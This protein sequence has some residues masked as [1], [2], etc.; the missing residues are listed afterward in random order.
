MKNKNYPLYLVEQVDDLQELINHAAEKYGDN[1]AFTFEQ[2]KKT[3]SISYRKFKADIEALGTALLNAGVKNTKVAVIGEN[4]YEWILTYFATVNSGN[5]IVPL[6][7][8]LPAVD[9]KNLIDTSG[10]EV[11]VHS[12]GYS[13]IAEYLT[14]NGVNIRHYIC[15]VK[16]PDM[17][18]NGCALIQQGDNSMKG[19]RVDNKALAVLLYTSGTTGMAKGVM[20]THIGLARGTAACLMNARIIGSNILVMPL[21]HVFGSVAV[22]CTM[23]FNGNEIFIN[24]N[25][26][27]FL[28]DLQK[29]KPDNLFVVPLFIET[30][31]KKI[32][33]GAKEKGKDGL[34]RKMITV[35]NFLLKIGINVRR[36]LFKSVLDAFGGNLKLLL[37]GGAPIDAKYMQGLRDFGINILNGYG[38]T[39]CSGVVSVTRNHYYR[40]GSIGLVLPCCEVKISEPDENDHGEI[41]V[42]GDNVMLGYYNNEQ[43]PRLLRS[44]KKPKIYPATNDFIIKEHCLQR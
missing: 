6:D 16:L 21:H 43:E 28:T 25:L 36:R 4:S 13:H 19:F 8:E 5:V 38:L 9:I 29:F 41:C 39:E 2:D 44:T 42:K 24:S 40:D 11:L 35:S 37:S 17:I 34:L 1:P 7:R 15:M 31:Y 18:K 22:V 26:M 33:S 3:V 20:L 30:F 32:W 12:E 23:L 10:A 14:D 27:N